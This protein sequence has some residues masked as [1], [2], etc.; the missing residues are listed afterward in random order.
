MILGLDLLLFSAPDVL[1][2]ANSEDFEWIDIRSLNVE[3]KGWTNTSSFYHRLP[4]K[5]EGVAP[6]AV[7]DLSKQ[8]AG[9][10]VRFISDAPAISARW[11]LTSTNLALPHMAATG[12]SGLDLYVRGGDRRWRWLAVG[13]PLAQTNRVRLISGL[14][15]EK[16]E[17]LLYL[18]LYN[19]VH[20]L[21]LGVPEGCQLGP[22]GPWGSGVRKPIVF[23]GTSITQGA[24]A[25]RS[26]MPHTAILGRHFD[27]PVINLGFSGS[28]KMEPV[29]AD[30]IAELD[31]SVYVLDCLPNLE[32]PEIQERLEP[33]IRRLR[34]DHPVTPIVLVEDR[35]YAN[36]HLV[37][38]NREHQ[39]RLRAVNRGCYER[40]KKAGFKHLYYLKGDSLLG[41]DYEGTV[42]SSHP[43][44][45][46]FM[47][48]AEA[49]AR[50]LGPLLK[51]GK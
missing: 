21:E 47:R 17:Y 18:P 22:S 16:R 15:P 5:A 51:P 25:S 29:M 4:A 28:G 1:G 2:A 19:G 8:T 3:G 11:S 32:V 26:G 46:G 45:L 6:G 39:K 23:Y 10:L 35:T 38:A 33:F 49:F 30:L 44:E 37:S 41:A 48:Q 36:A 24:C 43:N 42:D 9:L 7:Y 50:V 20:A 14:A 40:L 27:W 12:V 31:A 13:M 34:R